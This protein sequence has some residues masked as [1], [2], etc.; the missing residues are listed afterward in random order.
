MRLQDCIAAVGPLDRA[1][2]SA[3]AARLDSLTKPP[4]SLGRLERLA[5]QVAGITGQPRPHLTQPTIYV[6]AGDHGVAAE[7]VSAFP[8]AVTAQMV[9]NFLQ[10]GAAINVLARHA[11]ARVVV[12]DCGVVGPIADHPDLRRLAIAPG[13]ANFVCGPAMSAAQ[14][15]AALEAGISLVDDETDLVALGEMGIANTTSASAIIAACTG[16]PA[17][18]VT[19]RGT[20]IDEAARQHKAQVIERALA[21]AGVGPEDPLRIL[22]EVGGFEIGA[23]AGVALAAGARRLPVLVDGL[24][25]TS[26]AML[27]VGLCPQ[28]ADYLIAAHQGVEP[29]HRHALAWLEAEPLLELDLRL[30]EGSGAALAIPLVQAACRILDEMATF[31]DAAVDGP[32]SAE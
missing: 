6:C 22:Q 29:G 3:A 26:A 24:I 20:G 28:L 15:V 2:S 10:G 4:G 8:Q 12:A 1:A 27:A 30:G 7:G 13:T 16:C 11:G 32:G 31:A 14:A 25:A 17:E 21:R 5:Q 23:L 9:A 18:T 19:G